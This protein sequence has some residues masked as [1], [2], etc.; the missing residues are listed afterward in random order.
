MIFNLQSKIEYIQETNFNTFH[1]CIH[2]QPDLNSIRN[3]RCIEDSEEEVIILNNLRKND[4]YC[5]DYLYI[6]PLLWMV[7]WNFG[8]LFKQFLRNT[9][10]EILSLSMVKNV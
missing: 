4:N 6:S 10:N 3:S 5:Q 7:N 2:P 9:E 8:S 1:N